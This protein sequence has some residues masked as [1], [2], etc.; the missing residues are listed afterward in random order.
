M[1]KYY[2]SAIIVAAGNSTRMGLDISKQ[3]I[4]LLDRPVISY[5]ISAFEKAET[6][7]EI[8]IVCRPQDESQIEEIVC[9][10]KYKKVSAIVNGGNTR[11]ESVKNGITAANNFATH[12]AIHD[13]ARPLI[14]PENINDVVKQGVLCGAATLGT[15]VT[16]TIK[17]V[18]ETNHIMS[19]PIRSSLR[20]VQT[21]QVFERDL[22]LNALEKAQNSGN[23]FT[24]DCQLIENN[25]QTVSVVIGKVTNIKLT[26][27]FDIVL[28]ETLLSK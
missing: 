23:N 18:N 25:G 11:G 3:F 27:P 9:R 15:Y 20:A 19:T 8:V 5:T 28:A 1:K 10:Y 13:G 17:V 6:I 22:Y 21:P 26:T 4:P 7:E 14:Q 12:F 16:D 2:V 24:D